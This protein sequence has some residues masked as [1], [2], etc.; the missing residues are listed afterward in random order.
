MAAPVILYLDTTNKVIRASFLTFQQPA[1]GLTWEAGDLVP[2]QLHF[3]QVNP[4]SG[5][6]GQLPF[7]YIDPATVLPV[8]LAIGT[9]GLLPTAGTFTATYGANT[10]AALAYNI[11]ASALSTALNALASVTS[12]GG[13]VVS[14]NAGG[15]WQI[16]FNT[17]GVIS[18]VF[19]INP[20]DLNPPSQGIVGVAVTGAPGIQEIQVI[21]LIQN[22]AALQNIWTATYG[23]ITVTR[24]QAGGG[25]LNEIQRVAIPQGTYAGGFSLSFPIASPK[26]TGSL[27]YQ[28]TAAQVQAALTALTTIGAGNAVVIQSSPTTWDVTFTG[29]L[30]GASQNLI[31][32]VGTGLMMPQYLAG[33]LNLNVQGIFNLL[34]GA[35]SVQSVLQIQQGSPGSVNTVVQ[36]TLTINNTLIVGNPAVPNPP[37]ASIYGIT[38]IPT[39][40]NVIAVSFPSPLSYTPT[41]IMCG[42]MMPNSSGTILSGNVDNSSITNAGFNFICDSVPS[43][44][45]SFLVWI[46]LQ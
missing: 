31:A 46:T 13:V 36:T 38:A 22:P 18:T 41:G 25:G 37:T 21:S 15:P 27:G 11:T 9:I 28:A 8:S 12:A 19:S 23:A 32:A 16:T 45:G 42:V 1:Q 29:T 24:L 4:S 6:P 26:S 2:L 39:G 35:A 34:N 20:G 3:L 14:G 10:T 33:N 7:S 5:T 43:A 30:A 17:P 44:T 40:S